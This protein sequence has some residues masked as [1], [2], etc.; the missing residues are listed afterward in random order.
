[1]ICANVTAQAKS[2]IKSDL[3]MAQ[4]GTGSRENTHY[5]EFVTLSVIAAILII[6]KVQQ[7]SL[8]WS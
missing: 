1:M 6:R 3:V 7:A 5:Q 8:A 4:T 2:F